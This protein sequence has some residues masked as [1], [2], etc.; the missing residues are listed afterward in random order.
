MMESNIEVSPAREEE[1]EW[2]A[3]VMAGSDPWIML[4]RS[5]DACR[6]R[7]SDPEYHLFVARREGEPRGFILIHPHGLA[8]SPY[9]AS[10]AV[11]E[12]FRSQG[13]GSHLLDFAEDLFRGR[14]RYIFLC[15]SS[16]TVRARAL[17]ERRGYSVVGELKDYLIEGASEILMHKRLNQP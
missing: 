8:G 14:S 9:V 1:H 6:V 4:G 3:E 12:Q 10:V 11:A 17:Y 5:L 15:V 16:F 2:A 7:C 13:I